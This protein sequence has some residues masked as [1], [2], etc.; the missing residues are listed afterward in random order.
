MHLQNIIYCWLTT[1]KKAGIERG[2][3]G[4]DERDSSVAKNFFYISRARTT[5]FYRTVASTQMYS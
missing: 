2:R 4:G 1:I 5:A 3:E